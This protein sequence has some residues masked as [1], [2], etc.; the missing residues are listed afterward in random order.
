MCPRPGG[1]EG[2]SVPGAGGCDFRPHH[3]LP[4]ASTS[5]P[6]R[7]PPHQCLQMGR[8]AVPAPPVPRPTTK[9][10]TDP[11]SATTKPAVPTK[12]LPTQPTTRPTPQVCSMMHKTPGDAAWRGCGHAALLMPVH[13]CRSRLSHGSVGRRSPHPVLTR[14]FRH[15]F[16][17]SP[18]P[19]ILPALP[20]SQFPPSRLQLR[21]QPHRYAEDLGVLQEGLRSC[22]L[23]PRKR[24][25]CGPLWQPGECQSRSQVALSCAY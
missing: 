4:S 1:L 15:L 25:C 19:S 9:L 21:S 24:S 17:R 10:P 18:C 14:P 11:P 23:A 5:Q 20:R 8:P 7:R 6:R 2:M 13:V 12:P 3:A 16:P 22:T